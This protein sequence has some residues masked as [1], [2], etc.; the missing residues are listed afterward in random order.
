[1]FWFV[2]LFCL[3]GGRHRA[4]KKHANRFLGRLG[5]D[6]TIRLEIIFWSTVGQGESSKDRSTPWT[7]R[8]LAVTP[9]E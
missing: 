9:R 1:M 4:S 8:T 2:L 5:K 7:I 6:K 3:G